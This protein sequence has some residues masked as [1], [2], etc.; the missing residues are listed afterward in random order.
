MGLEEL[1]KTLA[2]GQ[3]MVLGEGQ[4]LWRQIE[5]RQTPGFTSRC[6]NPSEIMCTESAALTCPLCKK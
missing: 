6:I 4:Y 1:G 2:D 3:V 5:Q